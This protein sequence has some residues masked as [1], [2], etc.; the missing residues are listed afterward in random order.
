MLSKTDELSKK[1]QRPFKTFKTNSEHR[2]ASKT[3]VQGSCFYA[4]TRQLFCYCDAL[5]AIAVL[6][7]ALTVW[8]VDVAKPDI[9]HYVG[10][11]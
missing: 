6:T 3:Y 4:V 5:K 10:G 1:F 9:S 7:L 2:L 8:G 11:F